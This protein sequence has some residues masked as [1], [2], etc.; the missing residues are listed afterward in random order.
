M[1]VE[2]M[3]TTLLKLHLAKSLP[4]IKAAADWVEAMEVITG[5]QKPAINDKVLSAFDSK[6]GSGDLGRT[7]K[8]QL[9]TKVREVVLE[10]SAEMI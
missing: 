1:A 7:T 10:K 4:D 5:L 2:K 9:I 8:E 6:L 3:G